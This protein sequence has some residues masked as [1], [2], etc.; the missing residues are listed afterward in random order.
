MILPG[1]EEDVDISRDMSATHYAA[2]L[3]LDMIRI[4]FKEEFRIKIAAAKGVVKGELE[5]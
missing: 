1:Y 3:K 2:C 4:I 5:R